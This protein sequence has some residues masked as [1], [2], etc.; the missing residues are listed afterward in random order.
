M[1]GELDHELR[2]A[3]VALSEVNSPMTV[4]G[5]SRK[6]AT[7]LKPGHIL[8]SKHCVKIGTWNVQT[9]WDT[10]KGLKLA[11][12]MDRYGLEI[13]GVSECRYTGAG[14]TQIDDKT[15][16]YSGRSDGLHRDGVAL[17]CS[18]RAAA[19][20]IE[21]EPIDE[22]ILVA[23]FHAAGGKMT[24][25][26]CYSPTEVADDDKKDSFYRKLG[27]VF[28][29]VP[30]HDTVMVIGDMNAKVGNSSDTNS[31]NPSIGPHGMGV[32]NDNG[33][34]LVNFCDRAGLIIGGTMF[35]H[36]DIHKGTWRSPNMIYVNQIDHIIISRR[37]RSFLKDVRVFR[38]A[39]IGQTDHYL[40]VSKVKVKLR[41]IPKNT[42]KPA[43]D[44]SKLVNQSVRDE[45]N[46]KLE[47]KV[48]DLPELSEI[49]EIEEAWSSLKKAYMETAEEVLGRKRGRR[50]EWISEEAWQVIQEKKEL[51]VKMESSSD[52]N[53][54]R[55]YRDLHRQKA[56]EVKTI[57]R[58]DKRRFYHLKAEEA[59][60]A[61][62]LGDQRTLYRLVKDLGG[63]YGGGTE[64]VIKDVHGN[65]IVKEEDKVKR[66][67]EHFESVLN[68]S[69]P[70]E[71]HT[72]EEFTGE[73][74]DID[75]ENIRYEEVCQAISRLKNN[76]A[77]GEDLITGEMLKATVQ[78][79]G[80][81]KLHNL[82]NLIWEAEVC[83]EE[84]KYG[85]II[86]LPK[87]GNL[88]DCGNW[89]GITLLSVPGKIL[90][91]ILLDRI[92]EAI[93]G[94][95]REGQAGFRGGR[96]CADQIFVLRNIIEQ[97][98]E[99]QRQ[100]VVN[101]IDFKKAFDSLH[102]NSMWKILRSYGLPM[103]I[104]N[105]IKLLYEGSKSCVRVGGTNTDYFDITS[106]VKQGDVLSP[107]LFIVMVDWILRRTVDGEDGIEWMGT[108]RLP[109]LAYADDI[110]LLS[111]DADSMK[112]M[113]DKLALEASRVG[114]EINRT[115]TKL[116]AVQPREDISIALEGEVIG[117]V[118]SFEYLGS[119]VCHDG[120]VRKEVGIRAGKAGA[121]FSKMKKVWNSGGISL[122]T[123]L[124]LFNAT[125]MSVLLYGS[126]T[127]KGLKEIENK[128]R[129]FESNC[130]RK[131]MNIKWYEH[132][133][134][135]EVRRRSG[136][137]SVIQRWKTQRWR[138]YGHV[139]R[140]SEER[141]PKQVLSWTPEG[142]RRR[143]RPKDTWR[144]TIHRDVRS[145]DLTDE[146][147]QGVA[148]DREEWRRLVADLWAT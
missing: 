22:R 33:S 127:W 96:S 23:R 50:E 95:I 145:K 80:V 130:L 138:Y 53:I 52:L 57:T 26:M 100:L 16:I 10:A 7:R 108:D 4:C 76:K 102:R 31:S 39:D 6:E 94:R 92:Y 29:A 110:A 61:S 43:F 63:T 103:K 67:R 32:R 41:K 129:V 2:Q 77:P 9:L 24:L 84:W 132:V 12:E 141:L 142:R 14:R 45:F 133:T 99:W 51:K 81:S 34:R 82:L 1:G 15:V 90:A 58:R 144:R 137:Q 146:E 8:T 140:M 40:V 49:S 105:M 21:W 37:H 117:R 115:K 107:I 30:S 66:W 134:E 13:L 86:K 91:M 64:G 79:M 65:N 25:I 126:E 104:I 46:R 109:E 3:D 148:R 118:E 119:V 11:R 47:M 75:V 42:R 88:A 112:T 147:V 136:Q 69:T 28:N 113:T 73:E 131:I 62:A 72:F 44:S 111:D 18:K 74:L 71:V 55:I 116:M 78:G 59:E 120:D 123:K 17:F 36:R 35:P 93:D 97:S 5:Q 83:P 124:K 101:F 27:D 85:T 19:A 143:G 87:K 56:R 60:R 89:R 125:V 114:L 70:N 38:G 106:G 54:K 68:G 122:K 139:L 121:V 98:V 128:L 135:E 20:L 48:E